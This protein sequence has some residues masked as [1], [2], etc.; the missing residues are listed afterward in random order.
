MAVHIASRVLEQLR[1]V[2]GGVAQTA[3]SS[4]DFDPFPTSEPTPL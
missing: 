4:S 1:G 3:L 2:S